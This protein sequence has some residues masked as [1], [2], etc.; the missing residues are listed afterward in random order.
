[1][2]KYVKPIVIEL[3]HSIKDAQGICSMGSI[4]SGL[5]GSDCG[6]GG[7]ARGSMCFA[8]GEAVSLACST[9][10]HPSMDCITGGT[11]TQ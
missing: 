2:S 10:L 1:M 9:G 6:S 4:A 7:N 3:Q 8:N 11:D 5:P